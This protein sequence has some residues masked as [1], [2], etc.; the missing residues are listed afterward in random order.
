M[1]KVTINSDKVYFYK[2]VC[3]DLNVTECYVGH[4][5][6]FTKR[7]C[8][9]KSICNNERSKSYDLPIYKFIRDHGNWDN[10]DMILIEDCKCENRLDALRKERGYLE[11]V[12]AS[13]NL[14]IPS[15]SNKEWCV[16]NREKIYETQ[17]KY[18]ENNRERINERERQYY[19][20]NKEKVQEKQK[21]EGQNT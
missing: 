6:N 8:T 19:D 1:P 12:K 5:T 10:W 15:R 3:K 2:I 9:H 18:K 11:Q 14:T 21:N 16:E 7:K 20:A 4:T 13:L 17:K